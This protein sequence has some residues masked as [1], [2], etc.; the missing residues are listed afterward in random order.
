MTTTTIKR[1][2]FYSNW[3]GIRFASASDYDHGGDD[4]LMTGGCWME[5]DGVHVI[6]ILSAGVNASTPGSQ[7]ASQVGR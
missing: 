3:C 4:A 1:F 6:T 2:E 7:P 5:L